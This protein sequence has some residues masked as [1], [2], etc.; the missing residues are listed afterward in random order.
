MSGFSP[1]YYEPHVHGGTFGRIA[2]AGGH[3]SAFTTTQCC[4]RYKLQY[5]VP[6]LRRLHPTKPPFLV[7]TQQFVFIRAFPA[8]IVCQQQNSKPNRNTK[9][10]H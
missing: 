2:K 4:N 8:E 3:N 10:S 5:R 1:A 9:K 7:R 6:H